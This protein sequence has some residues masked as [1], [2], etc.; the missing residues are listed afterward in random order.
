MVVQFHKDSI[1][2]TFSIL[3]LL[4]F[5]GININ[6]QEISA[7]E[8]LFEEGRFFFQRRDYKEAVYFFKKLAQ[9]YPQNSNYNFKVGEC[10]LNIPGQEY[11]AVKYLE[12]AAQNTVPKREYNG[13]KFN[14]EKA[15]LHAYFYLGNA[16]RADG[17]LD[18]ALK[19]Y[20]KFLDSPYFHGNYNL[21]VVE[22]E[23]KSCERAKIIQDTPVKLK[24]QKLGPE[25][26]TDYSEFNA[27]KS[28]DGNTL[29]FVRGLKF[30]DAIFYSIKEEGGWSKPININQDVVSD[31]DYYPTSLNH[32]GTKMLLVREV[33]LN[34]DIYI[35]YLKE[36]AW[37]PAKKLQGKVNTQVQETFASFGTSDNIIYFASDRQGGKG[38][39]D[40]FV[41]KKETGEVWGKPK[42]LGKVIN[43]PMDE[44]TPV[45]CKDG[46]TLFF[47]SKSHYNMGGYDIFYSYK[48]QNKWSIPRNIGYPVNTT[49]DDLFYIVDNSCLSALFSQIDPETG[50]SDIYELMV[51]E[52]LALPND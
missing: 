44:E 1:M 18:N 3:F 24:T 42:N 5:L 33:D 4:F 10:Y 14:F 31:G 2:K 12:T 23:I 8:E 25:I 32:D 50:S 13:R 16:Y 46:K 51:E 22:N 34:S 41:S 30:Y 6:A 27:L 9:K 48:N 39:K 7:P 47:S 26:N 36:G 35:S 20:N 49:R 21:T 11:L 45:V 17:Q 28:G 15:P 52:P 38:G 29:V 37:T 40:I 19:A 43:S